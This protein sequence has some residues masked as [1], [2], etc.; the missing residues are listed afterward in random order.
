MNPHSTQNMPLEN[1]AGANYELL[2]ITGRF[3][4]QPQALEYPKYASRGHSPSR[5][6]GY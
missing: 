5:Y 3:S 4:R 1:P 6:Q 2:R